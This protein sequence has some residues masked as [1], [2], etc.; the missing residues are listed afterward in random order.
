MNANCAVLGTGLRSGRRLNR[1]ARLLSHAVA[2][3]CSYWH[4]YVPL[5][6]IWA[7]AF[8][9]VFIDPTPHLPILFNWTPSVPY[10]VALME[11]GTRALKRGD[12]IVYHFD[13]EAKEFYP[14]LRAQP[15]FKE[16]R[17][18]PGDRV[19]VTRREVFVNGISVGIAKT[20]TFDRRSLDPIRAIVIPPGY[21]YVEGTDINSFDSRYRASGLVRENQIIGK[22][23]PLF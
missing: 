10:T 5:F 3:A 17:G 1:V 11:Y 6:A 15:F 12:F 14:G 7:L 9:R 18:I 8:V 4:L 13:G 23:M 16:I 21:Y 19:T 20:H 22:V 2:D